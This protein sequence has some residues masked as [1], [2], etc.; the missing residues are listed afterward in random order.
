MLLTGFNYSLHSLEI[1]LD[2]A[3]LV[4]V[5]AV[6]F[7]ADCMGIVPTLSI[8]YKDKKERRMVLSNEVAI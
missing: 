7:P 8:L 1:C 4:L 2:F 6:M 3:L 5:Y